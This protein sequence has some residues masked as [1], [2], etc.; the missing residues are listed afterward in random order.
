MRSRP[1]GSDHS[2]DDSQASLSD[3]LGKRT[4]RPGRLTAPVRRPGH[5][6]RQGGLRQRRL[7]LHIALAAHTKSRKIALSSGAPKQLPRSTRTA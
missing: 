4:E 2:G 7:T 1:S 5:R 6:S 3:S